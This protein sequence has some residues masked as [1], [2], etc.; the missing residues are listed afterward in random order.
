MDNTKQLSKLIVNTSQTA[1]EKLKSKFFERI[2]KN[3]EYNQNI[4]KDIPEEVEKGILLDGNVVVK[5]LKFDG[6]KDN[7]GM[8]IEPKYKPYELS[9]GQKASEMDKFEYSSRAVIIKKPSEEY[10]K[11]L[12][13]PTRE[14]VYNL[15]KEKE[16]IIWL[17]PN[18]L[19]GLA[20]PFFDTDRKYPSD[21]FNGYLTI[22]IT[23]IQMI[24]S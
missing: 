19:K 7:Q 15:L 16:T 24:E 8:L 17:S 20:L 12:N 18:T 5:L 13:Q 14:Y 9:N 21:E 11:S 23:A 6:I 1:Q 2:E 10:V 4:L 3:N 22:P